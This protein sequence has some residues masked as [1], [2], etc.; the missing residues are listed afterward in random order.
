M[1]IR[2]ILVALDASPHSL[3]ALDSAAEMA[4][5]L[6]VELLG[7]FVEDINLLRLAELP[8]AREVGFPSAV[9]RPL[10]SA[11]MER[12][13]K[14]AAEQARHAMETLAEHLPVR[15]SFRV[16][17]GSVMSELLAAAG[18]ADLVALGKAGRQFSSRF[19]LGSTAGAL[20]EKA[21]SALLLL[22]Q[23]A[24]LRGPILVAVSDASPASLR[25]VSAGDMLARAWG[26]ELLLLLVMGQSTEARQVENQLRGSIQTNGLTIRCRHLVRAE[27]ATILQAAREER[28][29]TLILPSQLSFVS[30]QGLKELVEA[31]EAPVFLVR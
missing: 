21:P 5:R 28:A 19:R 4:A 26:N 31:M 14:I 10:N 25:A 22:Q 3:A 6:E 24:Q 7:L 1:N 29:G 18:E 20:M 27:R 8:F 12:T 11:T 17:R 2:R 9:P 13:L 30:A 15:W 23:G 16:V